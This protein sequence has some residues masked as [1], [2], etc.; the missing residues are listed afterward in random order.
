MRR[1]SRVE[2]DKI[3][4]VMLNHILSILDWLKDKLPIQ[5]RKERWKNELDNCKKERTKLLRGKAD[6]KK[7]KRLEYLDNRIDNLN[8]LLRNQE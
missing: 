6:D 5:D 2:P 8:Q 3:G 1:D 4:G 7:I